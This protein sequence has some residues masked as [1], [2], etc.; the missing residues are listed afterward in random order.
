M[1]WVAWRQHRFEAAVAAVLLAVLT[2]YLIV[3]GLQAEALARQLGLSSCDLT[4]SAGSTCSNALTSYMDSFFGISVLVRYVLI[5]LPALL[6]VFVAAPLLAREVENGTNMFIWTQSITRTRWFWVKLLLLGGSAFS[7]AAA[8]SMVAQWWQQPFN[9]MYADGNWT[10][11]DV[12]G[13]APVAYALFALALGVAAGT[14]IQRTVP[15]MA[16]T[17]FIFV[18]ARFAVRLW[19]PWFEAPMTAQLPAPAGILRGVLQ[20]ASPTVGEA[21]SYV[22]YQPADRFWTFELIEMTIFLVPAVVLVV[23]TSWWVRHRV[24]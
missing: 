18:A 10:F 11:F 8:V 20:I 24:R 12:V 7:A 2:G 5:A 22:V 21:Q 6:G 19:R 23:L 14:A 4:S 3:S 15:A 13:P 1:I 9:Q 17:L 16:A